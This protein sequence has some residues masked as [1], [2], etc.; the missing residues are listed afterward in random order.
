MSLPIS[1]WAGIAA[2]CT[3]QDGHW[4]VHL[5]NKI[6]RDL[7]YE[8]TTTEGWGERR[9]KRNGCDTKD[10]PW[11]IEGN[12]RELLKLAMSTL[13]LILAHPIHSARNDKIIFFLLLLGLAKVPPCVSFPL[14]FP[15]YLL[16]YL[17]VFFF[18][19]TPPRY[20]RVFLFL[21][22]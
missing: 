19:A 9:K 14:L 18:F 12:Q 15:G 11:V 7:N 2:L 5:E 20:S 1:W 22:A 13:Y 3:N 8:E 21:C 10:C 6:F 17:L 4:R 16:Y